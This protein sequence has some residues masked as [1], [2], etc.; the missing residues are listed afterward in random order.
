MEDILCYPPESIYP[1]TFI[2]GHIA[3]L[4]FLINLIARESILGKSFSGRM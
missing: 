4:H 2:S 1:S 3:T